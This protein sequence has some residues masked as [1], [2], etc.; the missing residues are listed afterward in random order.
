M[1][2]GEIDWAWKLTCPFYAQSVK[3]CASQ[4]LFCAAPSLP[5]DSLWIHAPWTPRTQAKQSRLFW[6]LP[7]AQVQ[8]TFPGHSTGVWVK[9][10]FQI[11]ALKDAPI[12]RHSSLHCAN[13]LEA[14]PIPCPSVQPEG[15]L[16]WINE[17]K[18]WTGAA[19]S[20]YYYK[21]PYEDFGQFE[22]RYL[23]VSFSFIRTRNWGCRFRECLEQRPRE[24]KEDLSLKRKRETSRTKLLFHYTQ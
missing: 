1:E 4:T 22:L 21:G 2:P 6:R 9:G 10:S 13:C 15:T 12:R 24:F 23:Y 14:R 19:D 8:G 17:M 3:I 16:Q 11:R 7:L 20:H 5:K 18:A